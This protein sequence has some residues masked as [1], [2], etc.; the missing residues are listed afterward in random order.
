MCVL[1]SEGLVESRHGIGS[2]V[3][4]L[5][6]EHR[7]FKLSS[8]RGNLGEASGSLQT[9]VLDRIESVRKEEAARAFRLDVPLLSM[10]VRLWV[11]DGIPVVYQESCVVAGNWPILQ[12]YEPGSSLYTALSRR[13]QVVISRATETLTV[14]APP[15]NVAHVLDISP[16]TALF[17][18]ERV[19]M[20]A[21]GTAVL[22]DHAYMRSDRVSV[23]LSR[24]GNT[25]DLRYVIGE[26]ERPQ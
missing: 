19:S 1:E 2:F 3:T 6:E 11:I 25:A 10:I 15:P 23:P 16:G 26:E 5:N 13:L 14:S 8:F 7:G 18:S 21:G 9:V 4:G 12:D 24:N 17:F 20:D 22:F